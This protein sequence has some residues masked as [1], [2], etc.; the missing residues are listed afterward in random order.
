MHRLSFCLE[1]LGGTRY[2]K[3]QNETYNLA[4]T[5]LW[6]QSEQVVRHARLAAPQRYEKW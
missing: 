1:K 4:I 6:T 2:E 5:D 3:K